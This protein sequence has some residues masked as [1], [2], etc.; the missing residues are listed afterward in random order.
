[1][2]DVQDRL[3]AQVLSRNQRSR[4]DNR[5]TKEVRVAANLVASMTIENLALTSPV[6]TTTLENAS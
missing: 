5:W 3:Q 4:L 6:F 1:M 2:V